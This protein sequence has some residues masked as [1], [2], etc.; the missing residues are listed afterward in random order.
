MDMALATAEGLAK[1]PSVS[2]AAT[3]S[4]TRA[5]RPEQESAQNACGTKMKRVVLCGVAATGILTGFYLGSSA[6][7][8]VRSFVRANAVQ[9]A[10]Q[11]AHLAEMDSQMESLRRELRIRDERL[12]TL[13]GSKLVALGRP[14]AAPARAA[15]TETG[16]SND[17]ATPSADSAAPAQ[18]IE[19]L[20]RPQGGSGAT[21]RHYACLS[22]AFAGMCSFVAG[23]QRQASGSAEAYQHCFNAPLDTWRRSLNSPARQTT[24]HQ[25]FIKRV[26]AMRAQNQGHV[27]VAIGEGGRGRD[28]KFPDWLSS[29]RNEMDA[30]SLPHWA[31]LAKV[32]GGVTALF[33][34]HVLEHFTPVE[35]YFA[36][37]MA[38]LTL[39]P[40][41]RFRVAV[42][43]AYNPDPNYIRYIRIGGV[44]GGMGASHQVLW[45]KDT[46]PEIFESAGFE[47]VLHEFFD[48][49]G[50]FHNHEDDSVEQ[51]DKW[52]FVQRSARG[53][54]ELK[55][56][57]LM[58]VGNANWTSLYFDAVKP[59]SCSA[60]LD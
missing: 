26:A 11:A 19:P 28:E 43:D 51:I 20:V 15:R 6:I 44:P 45:T 39:K 38:F 48:L 29:D 41:G 54:Q 42:P 2:T 47:I 57:N 12:L 53:M 49:Q 24:P 9:R 55:R 4:R 7:M 46:L 33:A 59:A 35:V 14:V 32:S 37:S 50:T 5:T 3:P 56:L 16:C 18:G 10:P 36:A 17:T 8:S 1:Q 34:E 60:V 40:G 21:A 52:G 25:R 58:K 22:R 23:R 13:L 31:L 27:K 30:F